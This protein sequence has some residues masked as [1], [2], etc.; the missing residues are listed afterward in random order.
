MK[1]ANKAKHTIV[2][3]L[4]Y[5]EF[6]ESGLQKQSLVPKLYRESIAIPKYELEYIRERN[7]NAN[8]ITEA[9][10]RFG[11]YIYGIVEKF[12]KSGI[13]V[14]TLDTGVLNIGAPSWMKINIQSEP[15]SSIEIIEVSSVIC[16][17]DSDTYNVLFIDGLSKSSLND[18]CDFAKEKIN[19]EIDIIV[20]KYKK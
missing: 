16:T 15:L 3:S 14:F 17:K 18:A 20:K 7:S 8:P 12:L 1:H 5:A 19:K 13:D 10:N 11:Y 9:A 6:S 2:Y 4:D